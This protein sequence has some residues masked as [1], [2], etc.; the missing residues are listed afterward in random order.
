V[1]SMDFKLA[2]LFFFRTDEPLV[3]FFT[4]NRFNIIHVFSFCFSN[5]SARPQF[6]FLPLLQ[7]FK[8]CCSKG[9]NFVVTRSLPRD[10]HLL[11]YMFD[12]RFLSKNHEAEVSGK[13]ILQDKNL[14]RFS[15]HLCGR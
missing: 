13:K 15:S 6:L 2:P 5:Q 7:S 10:E 8:L 4:P 14:T 9:G 11:F 12:S 3:S 1:I